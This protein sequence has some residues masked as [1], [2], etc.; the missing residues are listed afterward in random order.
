M[1][2]PIDH[3][4]PTTTIFRLVKSSVTTTWRISS[5][6]LL[7]TNRNARAYWGSTVWVMFVGQQSWSRSYVTSQLI[8]RV[9]WLSSSVVNDR[10]VTASRKSTLIRIKTSVAHVVCIPS[11]RRKS[12]LRFHSMGYV[13]WPVILT[14]VVRD[15]VGRRRLYLSYTGLLIY[16]DFRRPDELKALSAVWDMNQRN[17]EFR[18]REVLIQV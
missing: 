14:P 13:C 18:K 17:F 2:S 9:W 7:G 5:N 10:C 3:L 6:R 12:L 4:Q 1:L 15:F 11:N 8:L 16:V